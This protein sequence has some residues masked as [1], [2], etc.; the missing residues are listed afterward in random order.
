MGTHS[1]FAIGRDPL[2]RPADASAGPLRGELL[3]VEHLEERARALAASFTL[4]RN[5]RRRPRRFLPRLHDNAR[6]LR[7]A[8]RA[9][10]HDVRRGEAVPP[11]AEWLLDNFHL[12]E[13]EI[14]EVQ[15]NLPQRYYLELPKIASR[16]LAGMAR[17]HAMALEFVRHSDARFDLP[18]LT[19]FISAYQ[20][21]A[22]L[23]LGE[24]WAWPSMLKLVLIENLRRLAAE[25][26]ESRA[27]EA[28]AERYFAEFEAISADGPLPRL[29]ATLS[30]GFVVQLLQRIRELGPRVSELRVE[31]ERRL[32]KLG[33]SIDQAVRAEHQRQTIGHVSIGN[34]ITSLRLVATLD[35]NRTVERVS[36]MEQVLRRDPAGIYGQMDFPSRDRYRQ[37]VEELSEPTGEAQLR[38]ALRAIESA[39]QSAEKQ[40][41]DAS[42]HIGYHL[43]G[44]GRR[45]FETDVAYVP[46]F[47]HRI[48][49]F[50][51][52]HAVTFYLG[53]IALL[54]G[55]GVA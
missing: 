26:M 2:R 52:A 12:V 30:N 43:I 49:R 46:R 36:L 42:T 4:A 9:L 14:R 23:T 39:R 40:P 37:A 48:R 54:T 3:S 19:H 31:I 41:G 1:I 10:A 11:A 55:L 16:E 45:D 44:P 18:R 6:V 32:E 7:H 8:Y 35:W 5:P 13:G 22:P 53:S 47:R 28:E 15:K 51:F 27:G 34:S 29:P 25:I 17:I 20:S 24:L 38:V 21:V 33:S 50:I